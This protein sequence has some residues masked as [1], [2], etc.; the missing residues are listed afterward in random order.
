MRRT[1]QVYLSNENLR[2]FQSYYGK[3]D[4]N[5]ERLRKVLL[6]Y[7]NCRTI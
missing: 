6:V 5:R 7:L 4:L 1:H 3:N 2:G